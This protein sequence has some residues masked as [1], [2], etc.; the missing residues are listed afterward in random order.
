[1]YKNEERKRQH[2][3]RKRN[4]GSL[5]FIFV[6]ILSF[7]SLA[8][9]TGI[10]LSDISISRGETVT[11]FGKPD[12]LFLFSLVYR[13]VA[14]IPPLFVK[15]EEGEPREIQ[16]EGVK[17]LIGNQTITME[18]EERGR[19]FTR[20]DWIQGVRFVANYTFKQEES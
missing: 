1:M 12:D 5:I 15:I 13:N 9:R 3:N 2:L 11:L 19:E 20:E 16:Y 18:P 17:L 4:V 10:E 8:P 14:G 7:G 6:L